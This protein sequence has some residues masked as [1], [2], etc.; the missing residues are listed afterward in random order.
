MDNL[1]FDGV[2]RGGG[3]ELEDL[4]KNF[5]VPPDKQGRYIFPVEKR[6]IM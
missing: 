6:C 5:S 4:V 3:L 1:V 2:G